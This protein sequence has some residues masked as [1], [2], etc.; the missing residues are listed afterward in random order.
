MTGTVRA[1]LLQ[2]NM[3]NRAQYNKASQQPPL[4]LLQPDRSTRAGRR[5]KEDMRRK[6]MISEQAPTLP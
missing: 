3:P 5:R 2:N 4:H 6:P 1:I